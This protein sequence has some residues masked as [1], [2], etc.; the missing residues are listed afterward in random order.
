VEFKTYP[1]YK[2]SGIEWLEDIPEH[3]EVK[4]VKHVANF[5]TG[6][7]PPSG[8]EE[9]YE[10][11]Y[12]WANISDLGAKYLETPAKTITQ[13]AVDTLRMKLS[14]K[15]S[16][17][18]SFKLSIGLVSILKK[19]MYTNEAIA[20][21]PPEEKIN[22]SFLY[23]LAPTAIPMNAG[24][25]IYN[26]PMLN[27]ESI[28]NAMIVYPPIDEQQAI[29]S[30]LD[31]ETARIDALIKKKERMIELLKEKRIALIT[32]AVTKGL[33]PN[34]PMKDSGIEWLGEVPEHWEVN[35]VKTA[36]QILRGRFN[37]RPRNDPRFYD[38][39][40]PFVQTG[41]VSQSGK[42]VVSYEQTL[43]DL[44][45]SISKEFPAGTLLM[46]IA[47]NIAD[48]SIIT[49]NA[50]APDSIV[51][52]VP[53]TNMDLDYLYYAFIAMRSELIKEAPVS[54]QSNL[55][56]NRIGSIN[57]PVPDLESQNKIVSYIAKEELRL[58]KLS[59]IN[60]HSITLLREYRSS[61]IHHAVT[62]KIDLREY[63]NEHIS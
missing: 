23:Y 19:D 12:P 30:F 63:A 9:F 28:K 45:Y 16:L 24:I 55:N 61:L 20:T 53:K 36:T 42:Y 60:Q 8:T 46:T 11:D 39:D 13:K 62:G 38:G 47:A 43:N 15:G 18:F 5:Y 25:N 41:D 52:L 35:A 54:T 59:V 31:R 56:I 22:T 34:V 26:A 10:G 2:E 40:Y 4:K 57:M 17:L 29:A 48:V 27:Q 51:G 49:F 37:F 44:G 21:F 50:C 1:D 3:W 33:D 6:W 7:T 58:D 14:Y 32:Q